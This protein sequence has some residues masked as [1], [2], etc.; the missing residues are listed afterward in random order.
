MLSILSTLIILPGPYRFKVI[1]MIK[2]LNFSGK[3]GLSILNFS[4]LSRGNALT[5]FASTK[6]D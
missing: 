1:K 2:V 4:R 3:E 6:N 5:L